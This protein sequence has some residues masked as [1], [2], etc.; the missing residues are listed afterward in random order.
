[1]LVLAPDV[2]WF[3]ELK[4]L[5]F[6]KPTPAYNQLP[7]DLMQQSVLILQPHPQ[8]PCAFQ[9]AKNRYLDLVEHTAALDQIFDDYRI[10]NQVWRG[11][12]I[13]SKADWC[14]LA[15]IAN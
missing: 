11:D 6:L 3:K 10:N 14:R 15:L 2:V 1:M 7:R 12:V 4:V 9:V 5:V 8:I 13:V